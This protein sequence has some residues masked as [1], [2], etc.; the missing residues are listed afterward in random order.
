[1]NVRDW[2]DIV[3]DVVESDA[4]PDGWRAVAGD[5]TGGLG[6]DFYVGHPS[7]GVFLLKT[8]A[9]NPFEV[10][11]VGTRVARRI[12]EDLADLFPAGDRGR[13]AVQRPPADE[14]D[15][16]R[17]AR[18]LETVLQTHA[19]APTEPADLFDDV[20]ETLESPAYGPMDYDQ[21][22]RP[23]GLDELADTFEEAEDVLDAEFEDLVEEDEVGRGFH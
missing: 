20:M 6:E 3:Q 2:Q 17:K 12:D 1:M 7:G 19:E 11:S 8:Y 4:D 14:D 9:K 23:D 5:R 18:D 21:F 22:D 15:A 16:E 10:R 13:F